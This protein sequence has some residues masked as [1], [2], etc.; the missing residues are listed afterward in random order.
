[1]HRDYSKHITRLKKRLYDEEMGRP[2]VSGAFEKSKYPDVVKYA[3][4]GMSGVDSSYNA[5]LIKNFQSTQELLT[6]QLRERNIEVDMRYQGAHNTDTHVELFTDL[7]LMVILKSYTGKPA[8]AV[9]TLASHIV[10]ILTASNAY[11]LID[12]SSKNRCY[13]ETRVPTSHLSILPAI[14]LDSS[15][16]KK[17]HLEINRG[18]C[19][20]NFEKKTRRMYLPFLNMA[21]LNSK[22]RKLGGSLKGMI[23]LLRSIQADSGHQDLLTH[24][25]IMGTLYNMSL[26]DL[27]VPKGFYLSLLPAVSRWLKKV[28][29]DTEFRQKLLSPSKKEYVFGNKSKEESIVNLQKEVDT[30]IDDLQEALK[31]SNMTI[32]SKMEY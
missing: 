18:V 23:R 28:G 2:V 1:M 25:E 22:D 30:L 7:E 21:R 26:R 19:E 15:E 32:D 14:W 5:K 6:S 11:N 10:D 24:D 16:Y 3:F 17:T 12:F 31:E 20:Y 27:T 8:K 4:E 9:Q 13:V 29:T